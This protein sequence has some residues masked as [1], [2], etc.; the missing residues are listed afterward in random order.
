M[1]DKLIQAKK[2]RKKS[3]DLRKTTKAHEANVLATKKRI[4]KINEKEMSS[5]GM[6]RKHTAGQVPQYYPM[7]QLNSFMRQ[8]EQGSQKQ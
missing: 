3:F 1:Q 4:E 5:K 7:A 2:A 8:S 6:A